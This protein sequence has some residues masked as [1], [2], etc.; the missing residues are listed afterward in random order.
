MGQDRIR[1][2]RRCCGSSSHFARHGSHFE[3]AIRTVPTPPGGALGLELVGVRLGE[4]EREPRRRDRAIGIGAPGE[5]RGLVG[6]RLQQGQFL[7]TVERGAEQDLFGQRLLGSNGYW[8]GTVER[9]YSPR[10]LAS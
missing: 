3:V 4:G 8:T 2:T 9:L 6:A 7:R 10:R 5:H 1:S